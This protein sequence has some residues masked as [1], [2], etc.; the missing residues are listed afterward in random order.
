MGF[1]VLIGNAQAKQNWKYVNCVNKD[2]AEA[3]EKAKDML[4]DANDG[5]A[6]WKLYDSD[7]RQLVASIQL[8][9]DG[10][11]NVFEERGINK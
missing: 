1:Y 5:C 7:L 3:I 11:F 2:D 8:T 4:I 9:Q 6:M 10:S